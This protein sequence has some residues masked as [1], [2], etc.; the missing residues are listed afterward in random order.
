MSNALSRA[1]DLSV[2]ETDRQKHN[3][4]FINDALL[5]ERRQ[6]RPINTSRLIIMNSIEIVSSQN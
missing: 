6:G 3:N 2:N 4:C 1:Y 5:T